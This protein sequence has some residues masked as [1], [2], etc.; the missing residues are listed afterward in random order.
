VLQ[1]IN[2]PYSWQPHGAETQRTISV[3]KSKKA[4]GFNTTAL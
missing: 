3:C 4:V 2:K 1:T